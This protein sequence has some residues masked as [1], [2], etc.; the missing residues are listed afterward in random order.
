M[1][2]E[3]PLHRIKG[4]NGVLIYDVGSETYGTLKSVQT[5]DRP[6]FGKAQEKSQQDC[7]ITDVFVTTCDPAGWVWIKKERLA[8]ITSLVKSDRGFQPKT[9]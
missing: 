4:A 3:R 1:M 5:L 6:M 9:N 8:Q 2:R 7:K